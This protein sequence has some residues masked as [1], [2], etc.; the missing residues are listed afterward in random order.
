MMNEQSIL[1]FAADFNTLSPEA[2]W[3]LR[4]I[5]IGMMLTSE[6]DQHKREELIR[7]GL[8]TAA[9]ADPGQGAGHHGP[10]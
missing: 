5:Q 8:C 6:V 9:V 3:L 1:A 10:H 2:G 7:C 4:G